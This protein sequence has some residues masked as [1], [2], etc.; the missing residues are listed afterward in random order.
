MA[1]RGVRVASFLGEH[2]F[3]CAIGA[4]GLF[5]GIDALVHTASGDE[6][7]LQH[8]F[9]TQAHTVLPR[10]FTIALIVGIGYLIRAERL[11][12]LSE[13]KVQASERRFRTLVGSAPVGVFECDASGGVVSG[14]DR[15][16]ALLGLQPPAGFGEGFA[17]ALH[18][19]DRARVLERWAETVRDGRPFH[20]ECRFSRRDGETVWV[21][22]EAAALHGGGGAV[23]GFIGTI[24][25][26]TGRVRAETELA[27]RT[28]LAE[29]SAAVGVI[30]AEEAS[31]PGM[32]RRCAQ[33]MVT[34]LDALFARI[35]LYDSRED[36]LVLQASEG[37]YTHLDGPHA[38][39][40]PGHM[41][42]GVI[43][44]DRKPLL[45]NEVVGDPLVSDQEWARREGVTAFAGNPLVAGNTLIGVMGVFSRHSLSPAA[46]DWLATIASEIALGIQ[47]RRLEDR[48]QAAAYTDDLT[49]LFNRRGFFTLAG[50]QFEIAVRG[51]FAVGLVYLDLNRMKEINDRHGH[52]EGDRALRDVGDVLR[53]T[54]RT[55]DIIARI[56]GDEFV[57]FLSEVEDAGFQGVVLSNLRKKLADHNA[58]AE[59]PFTLELSAGMA[60]SAAG[61]SC[62]LEELLLRADRDMY[63]EKRLGRGRPRS[64]VEPARAGLAPRLNGRVP[65]E[66]VAADVIPGG[67]AEVVDISCGG[68]CLMTPVPLQIRNSYALRLPVGAASGLD[69]AAEVIWAAEIDPRSSDGF[70]YRSG[71]RFLDVDGLPQRAV[72]GLVAGHC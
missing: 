42:I 66:G 50:K 1:G 44:S 18:E 8:L 37:R 49:G 51:G 6:G 13:A 55:S 30:L 57:V 54:F 15:A 52:K 34:H 33:T 40:P 68:V 38:R 64:P 27:E 12:R 31:L 48:L 17:T 53:Q 28:R 5:W 39:I 41:N 24:T 59:R 67:A 45:T 4:A 20:E 56:G 62:R 9:S 46:S 10:L 25:D 7:F 71:L 60:F 36:I 11:R 58:H 69:L 43:A 65:L 61:D 14:N 19:A 22:C 21:I 47:R 3:G 35:W 16:W 72:A 2:A 32:L 26:I 70:R 63:R 29:M 23:T